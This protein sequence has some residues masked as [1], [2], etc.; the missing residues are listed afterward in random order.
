MTKDSVSSTTAPGER[1]R[2]LERLA[3][4][5]R[6]AV[7]DATEGPEHLRTGRFHPG[8]AEHEA[9]DSDGAPAKAGKHS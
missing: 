5:A 9:A 7:W 3:E 1:E 2:R 8:T 6:R 4:A